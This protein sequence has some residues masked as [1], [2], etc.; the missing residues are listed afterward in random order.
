MPKLESLNIPL[1]A[2]PLTNAMGVINNNGTLTL[3]VSSIH[4]VVATM[5]IERENFIMDARK[6]RM[7]IER[8]EE[9]LFLHKYMES[10][11]NN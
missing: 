1:R 2:T 4:I 5:S 10:M 11:T 3:L 7:V 8:E 6:S 9:I